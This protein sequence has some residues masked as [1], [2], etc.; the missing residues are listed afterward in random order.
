[1]YP[2][3]H[4]K[5]RDQIVR[6]GVLV[7]EL[8][9]GAGP[10]AKNFPMRNRII[11]GMS[12]GTVV[13]EAAERSGSLITANYALQENRQIFAVPGHPL[14]KAYEGCNFLLRH[15]AIPVRHAGDL[16]EDLAP[17]LGITLGG[18]GQQRIDFEQASETLDPDERRLLE[19]L[20]PVEEIHADKL[21]DKLRIDASRLGAMLM[22]LEMKGL[23]QRLPGDRYRK[24]AFKA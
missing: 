2:K 19:L 3:R 5:L 20:D 21:A 13:V 7:S 16:L 10:E 17:Q 1:V 14:S 11:A 23:V 4:Q 22:M 8:F 12:V 6:E 15:G 9:L 18:G 24:R